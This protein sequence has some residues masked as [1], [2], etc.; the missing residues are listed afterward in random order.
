MSGRKVADRPS[1]EW[2]AT[3]KEGDRVAVA[4]RG[5][6]THEAIVLRVTPGG[7][8]KVGQPHSALRHALAFYG[9]APSP[10]RWAHMMGWNVGGTVYSIP[11]YLVP[12]ASSPDKEGA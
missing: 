3:L 12:V 1:P 7:Q 5:H 10:G 6:V 8:I 11:R 4:E 9:A 2:V